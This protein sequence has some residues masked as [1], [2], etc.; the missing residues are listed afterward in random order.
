MAI[1]P[2]PTTIPIQQQRRDDDKNAGMERIS[3]KIARLLQPKI[4][5]SYE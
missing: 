3:K 5:C 1:D 4:A 2:Y